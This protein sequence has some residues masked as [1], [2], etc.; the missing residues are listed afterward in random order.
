MMYS[1]TPCPQIVPNK[2][3]RSHRMEYFKKHSNLC[4]ANVD[5][6]Q[7]QI[8]MYIWWGGGV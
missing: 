8:E 3:C 6:C 2:L 5:P 1:T 7:A 4:D